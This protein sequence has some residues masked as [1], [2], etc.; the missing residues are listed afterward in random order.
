VKN[1]HE[2]LAEARRNILHGM[3]KRRTDEA[4]AAVTPQAAAAFNDSAEALAAA[5]RGREAFGQAPQ[6]FRRW[7]S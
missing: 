5:I 3:R 2:A 1:H 4:S 6:A 7:R